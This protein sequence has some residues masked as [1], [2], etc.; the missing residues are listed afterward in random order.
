VSESVSVPTGNGNVTSVSVNLIIRNTDRDDMGVYQC[1]ANNTISRYINVTVL[2]M[3]SNGLF[4]TKMQSL[5]WVML[6]TNLCISS[7]G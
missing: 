1:T 2:G 7:I 4:F 6:C 5:S 3:L